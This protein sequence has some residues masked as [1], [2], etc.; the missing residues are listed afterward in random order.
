MSRRR[1]TERGTALIAA[2]LLVALMAA[3]SVQLVDLTRFSLARTAQI[4]QRAQAYWLARGARDLAEQALVQSG[5]AGRSV[6]RSDE[7]WRTGPQAF[8]VEGGL[9][10]GQ[11]R[12]GNNC[13]NLNALVATAGDDPLTATQR[14]AGAD[15]ARRAFGRLAEAQ[16]VPAG[17]ADTVR[18][19]LVDWIDA[20]GQPEL[21]GAE[22]RAY[23]RFD[24][25]Y[26]PANQPLVELEE[27]RAL[28]AVTPTLYERLAAFACVRPGFEQPALNLNTLDVDQAVLLS[29]AFDG[30]LSVSDAEIVLFRRPPSG[31]ETLDAFWADPLIARLELEEGVRSRVGLAT[32]WFEIDVRVRLS[33]ARFDLHALAELT[34]TGA[35]RPVH[36]RFGAVS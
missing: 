29:A 11:I 15:W 31:Y 2:L 17:L 24:P 19:Q 3:V 1:E 30:A 6:M 28:P 7:L 32:R 20:D 35:L 33:D 26:R 4:D 22:D 27:L 36:Q 14:E 34:R 21:G 9:I 13:L 12:D 23:A 16:G 25:P 5:E 10:T 18:A 8:P